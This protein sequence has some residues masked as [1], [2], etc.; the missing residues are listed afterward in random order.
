FMYSQISRI[1][2]LQDNGL[3]VGNY[4]LRYRGATDF[5]RTNGVPNNV[6]V[7]NNPID[8]LANLGYLG[9][10]F[11]DA[12]SVN[13]RLTLN[14]RVRYANDRGWLPPQCRVAA[15]REFGTVFPAQCWD[16]NQL[17]T[18]NPVTPRLHAAFDVTGDGRTVVKGGWGRF[19]RMHDR[20]ELDVLNPNARKEA[21]FKWKDLNTNGYFDAGESNL[22]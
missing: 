21:R 13:R 20:L 8:P 18:W 12:W 1:E 19:Y 22:D 2:S 7:G 17:K 4:V 10:H 15:P 14:L 11:Q 5:N 6:R 9:L 3:P 16:R